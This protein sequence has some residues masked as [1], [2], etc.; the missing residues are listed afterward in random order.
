ME[1]RLE[2]MT[3]R[4]VTFR[5]GFKSHFQEGSPSEQGDDLEGHR[6]H[7]PQLRGLVNSQLSIT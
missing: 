3:L 5:G 1:H 6:N 2:V 7:R 4:E